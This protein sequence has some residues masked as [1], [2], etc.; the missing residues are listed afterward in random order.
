VLGNIP[1]ARAA[2]N[3]SRDSV[4]RPS[5]N[6]SLLE[7]TSARRWAPPAASLFRG[8]VPRGADF[9][10]FVTALKRR[11]AWG[12]RQI[13]SIISHSWLTRSGAPFAEE[14][15]GRYTVELSVSHVEASVTRIFRRVRPFVALAALVAF[16]P[17][18]VEALPVVVTPG[19]ASQSVAITA[20]QN[21][22][23]TNPGTLLAT[24]TE[25]LD[26]G[27]GHIVGF[28][29]SAVYQN[30]SGFL[31]FYYQVINTTAP[32][33]TNTSISGLAAFNFGSASTA[34]G[35]YT[36][37]APFGGVF[38]NPF[39][40][41]HHGTNPRSADRS[42][43]GNVVNL[44]FGPPWGSVRIDAGETSSIMM[45]ATNATTFG[46]GWAT[47]QNGGPASTDTVR[48]FQVPE[49]MSAALALLGF[50]VLAGAGARRR[51]R[52]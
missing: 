29:T 14:P 38:A 32:G 42:A 30:A 13:A 51:Q 50:A 35:F 22:G 3:R 4:A 31:D 44:W 1:S 47:V 16:A 45:I 34:V 46:S 9:C 26:I 33:G 52:K 43:N 39:G 6:K 24:I 28:V 5:P 49:P 12:D 21:M 8:R 19:T 11:I 37:A 15:S 27:S 40:F 18:R 17:S 2:A 7:Q 25:A 36:S 10:L 48:S 20:A 41:F 23:A